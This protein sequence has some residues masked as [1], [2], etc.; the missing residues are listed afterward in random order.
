MAIDK[1]GKGRDDPQSG[2]KGRSD[3]DRNSKGTDE[4]RSSGKPGRNA[5]LSRGVGRRLGKDGR[6]R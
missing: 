5:E 1:N 6:G 2:L 4:K 3:G